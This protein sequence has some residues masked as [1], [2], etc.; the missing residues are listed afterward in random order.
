MRD[1]QIQ[2]NIAEYKILADIGLSRRKFFDWKSAY[3][4]PWQLALNL[5]KSHHLEDWEQERIIDFYLENERDGYR[6]C[7]YMMMDQ[8]IVYAAPST[9]YSVLKRHDAIRSRMVKISKKGTGFVQPLKAHEHW[10]S[11][12]TNVTVGDTVYFLISILDGYSRSI[13][14]WDLRKSMKHHDVAIVLQ[15]AKEA[16]PDAHPRYISDNGKQYKCKEFI[17]FI[18]ANDYTHVTT[19][20]Y[21]PQSNGKQERWHGTLK[22]ECIRIECPVNFEDAIKVIEKYVDHYNNHRLHSA[23][24]YISPKDKLAGKE[25]EIWKHRDEKL[26][27]RRVAR[28]RVKVVY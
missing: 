1:K 7:A 27:E 11:D 22:V 17:K 5:P 24:G 10:H 21:Y 2:T 6:R 20:P 8:D 16:Y 14:A 18:K 3:G 23:I 19:S 4:L 13:I 12:I 25:D 26:T 9:V 28:R 15:K